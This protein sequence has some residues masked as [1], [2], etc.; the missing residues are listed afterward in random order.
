MAARGP[1]GGC[2]WA[3]TGEGPLVPGVPHGGGGG[4]TGETDSARVDVF[5][6]NLG[7]AGLRHH[8]PSSWALQT[9]VPWGG[10]AGSEQAQASPLQRVKYGGALQDQGGRGACAL[11][12][13]GLPWG[14]VPQVLSLLLEQ[15]LRQPAA[16]GG[17]DSPV[18]TLSWTL[19]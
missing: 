14:P 16:P 7:L 17:T 13:A 2:F 8:I 15:L 12:P 1:Q 5:L 19:I 3:L 18:P 10:W 4:G 11:V 9:A 6:E